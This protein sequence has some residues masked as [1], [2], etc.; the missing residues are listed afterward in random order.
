MRIAVKTASDM[1]LWTAKEIYKNPFI[2]YDMKIK[3]SWTKVLLNGLKNTIRAYN[4]IG[5]TNSSKS[6][7]RKNAAPADAVNYKKD[8]KID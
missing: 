4:P 1:Y 7:D 8:K 2:V 5:K 3:P 6:F